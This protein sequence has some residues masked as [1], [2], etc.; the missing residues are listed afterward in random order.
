M[1]THKELAV[2]ALENMRG[3]DQYRAERA[4]RNCTPEQMNQEYGESGQTRSEI[5]NGYRERGSQIDGAIAWI[6]SLTPD[7]L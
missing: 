2:Q 3:D 1:S 7:S 6:N 4:F 5:L